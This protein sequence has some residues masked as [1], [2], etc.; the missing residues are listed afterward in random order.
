MESRGVDCIHCFYFLVQIQG[1]HATKSAGD[2]LLCEKHVIMFQSITFKSLGVMFML[3][4]V[5]I[6]EDNPP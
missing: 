3:W 5:V 2:A 6:L 4:N 1:A